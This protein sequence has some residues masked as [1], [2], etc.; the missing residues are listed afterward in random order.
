MKERSIGFK[1]WMVDAILDGR[2]TVTRRLIKEQP[3]TTE[4]RLREL[5]AWVE[6]QTLSQH[7]NNAW[8]AGFIPVDCP[9]GEPGDLLLIKET[10]DR[11]VLLEITDVRIEQL[12]VITI[13]EVCK[14]GLAR[15]I[16]EFIPVT[17]AFSCF[18]EVWDD[19]YGTGSWAANPW[20]WVV[21]F[22]QVTQ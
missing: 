8:R 7:V 22:K 1:E 2:K 21:E 20:V 9:Y 16:Y 5:G 18:E 4:Q 11:R 15:S 12:Q 13:G 17:S 10:G 6:G 19:I 3:D 14:E